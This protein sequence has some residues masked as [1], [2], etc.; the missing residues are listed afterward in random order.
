M[1]GVCI[2]LIAVLLIGSSQQTKT[3]DKECW[4]PW[5]DRD[6]PS[7]TGDWE[8]LIDLH[9]ENPGKIC[10]NPLKIQVQTIA[11]D[12]MTS[13]G[14]RILQADTTTGFICRNEDQKCGKCEDY[15]VR[16][17]CPESFCKAGPRCWTSWFNRD[18]PSEDGD[19]E[20]LIELW[21]EYPGKICTNPLNIEVQTTSG[22]SMA[23]T[24]DTIARADTAVGFVCKN[25]DQKDGKCKDYH[26]RFQC[27]KSFCDKA[28]KCW[29]QWFDRD[30][31]SAKG[32]WETLEDLRKEYPGKICD[33]PIHIHVQT[34]DGGHMTLTGDKIHKADTTTGFICRNEDQKKGKCKDYR[35]QFMCPLSFC[36]EGP[37]CWTQWFDRDNPSATGDWETLKD[38]RKEYPGKI[39]KNPVNILVQ[40]TAGDTMDSTGNKI[41]IADTTTGFVCR[42]EDQ[43]KGK[44]KDYRV[45]FQ[46]PERFCKA[47]PKCWTQWFDRDN[48]SA[49]GDWETLKDLRK[50][51][52]GKICKNPVNI[53]VQTI[54][55]GTMASTGDKIHIADTSTG[56][57]CRNEDQTGGNC[58]DYRVQFE[59]PASFCKPAPKCWTQWFDRDNPSAT[60]DWETLKDLRKENP[61]KI[62]GKPLK[63]QVQTTAGGTMASTGDKIHI[64]DTSTGFV[65]RNKDQKKGNC[66]DYRVRFQCPKMFCKPAPKCWTPWFDRDNPSATGDWETLKDLRKEN[67]GKICGKPLKIQVQTTAGGTMASTGDKIHIADTSTG[68]V[69]RNKDQKKGNCKDYRVRFQCPKM[70]CKPAPKCWT[71]WFDRDNPSATGDWETLK[72]LRKENPGK[73]CGNPLK[74]QVRTTAGGTMAS[75]GDKI[76]IA[77]TSTGFVCRNKDQTGGNCKDYRVRFQ[78]PAR[79]C[80]PAPKCWTPWF[81]RDNP[82][83]TGDWETLKDLRK[84]NP[85]K[86]CGNPLK[87]QVRTTA[88]GTMASTGDKIHKADTSTGFVCRNKDQTGGNCKDYRVRFQCPARFCKPAPKCWTPWFDRD[89]PSATG[90]WETLKDLRKENPGKICG[91]PLKIQVRTTAGGTMASTGDKIHKADTTTGFVCRNKDQT[92]GNCKDYR[93]RFQCPARFCKPGP[94]CWT[95]WFDRDNPSGSGDWETLK[96]LWKE[97]PGKICNSPFDIQVQTT[98][99][100]SMASTGDTIARV[101]TSTGFVCKNKDQ[102]DGKCKDYRVR[103]QC[104]KS[105]CDKAPKCWTQWFDRDN[106][107][108]TGDWETLKDLRK[109]YPG[110]ICDNPIHIHVQTVDGGHMASTGDKI[111]K[112][113][114]ST[115]FVCENKDQ[116]DGKCEDYRVRF[117]CP[118]S[119]CPMGPRCWT[120]W[121]D[122]DNPSGTGDWETLEYLRG[123]NPGKICHNPLQIDVQTKFGGSMDSTGDVITVADTESGFI[124]KNSDQKCGKCKD[125]RV[126]FQCS[127]NFCTQR[128]CWTKWFD[129]D[130][131]SGKG[132]FEYLPYL[133]KAYPKEIC[134]VPLYI[135]VVTTDTNMPFIATGQISSVFS[136]TQGFAC[137]N[138]EQKGGMCLDYKVRFGCPCTCE[139]IIQH[140]E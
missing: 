48:P 137:R 99:G 131:P 46:C 91:N 115:G 125:Y 98:S 11:G 83:A 84:E 25:K 51:N 88:G 27:F 127:G 96:D 92:G 31:P 45:Q 71:P 113:D 97:Y 30:N 86:I 69:C 117:Q 14:D 16:F 128:V 101:D 116:A 53:H 40:T 63:I 26:V 8:T 112:A 57:V 64:A 74:I 13:T 6:N 66:K 44:C 56:F 95:P 130:N 90:D 35:V 94:K 37:K 105:F 58:K 139:G 19:Q 75:T 62:C 118:S 4:T 23:S 17:Q 72:D 78:C 18:N 36:M 87:I 85:G 104:P 47:A 111:Y 120:P 119:F 28:P 70:F 124:C 29:T 60:G 1:K 55:G 100:D 65:C 138:T 110:K 79:F 68:F 122:R 121:F 135:D 52:P 67:P 10:G 9:K 50:E 89:N 7:A 80:K 76:H 2:T 136:P 15:R 93:V 102:K 77:D 59:C 109:E 41:H 133:R 12:S 21:K 108:A 34:V 107:S 134:K 61:G 33:N 38:L 129:R 126:R 103:F 43:K 132:D 140:R 24:G 42:N 81:D 106:P 49:K 73:I 32:D 82:S 3:K 39:C 123:E 54:A 22:D 114:T 20:T 5:F